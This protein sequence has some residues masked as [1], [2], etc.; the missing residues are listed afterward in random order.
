MTSLATAGS[1]PSPLRNRFGRRKFDKQPTQS[2]AVLVASNGFAIPGAAIRQALRLA[3]GEPVA[4]MSIARIYGSGLGLQNPGL[5]PTRKEM[6]QQ[7]EIVEKGIAAV[8]KGGVQAWGQ[9]ALSRKPVKT[10]VQAASVRGVGHVIVIRP[11][12]SVRWRQVVEGD[13]VKEVARKLGP[14]VTVEGVTP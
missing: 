5:M 12:Q 9:V 11:E 13:L 2:A 6:A 10:I 7:K 8:E 4:V 1:V 3:H 14:E